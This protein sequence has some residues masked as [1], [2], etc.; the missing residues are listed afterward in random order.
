M[1]A[2]VESAVKK[3]VDAGWQE[4]HQLY[5]GAVLVWEKK[6]FG[7][8]QLHSHIGFYLGNNI[9]VSNSSFNEGV[10][11]RHHYTYDNTRKIEKILW[12]PDLD[13]N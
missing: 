7:E 4:V 3:L 5:P 13:A 12:H 8:G 1:S 9:A 6:D 2:T 10:P 11:V